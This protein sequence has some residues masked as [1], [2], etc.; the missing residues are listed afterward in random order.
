MS[1][2][3]KMNLQDL[4]ANSPKIEKFFE[5][6]VDIITFDK[7]WSESNS[8]ILLKIL[9]YEV[10][11]SNIVIQWAPFDWIEFSTDKDDCWFT[12]KCKRK[13]KDKDLFS[14]YY[15]EN[16]YK[17]HYTWW[18]E[19]ISQYKKNIRGFLQ[20][21]YNPG[22][23]IDQSMMHIYHATNYFVDKKCTVVNM[24][25]N[26]II[27]HE[28]YRNDEFYLSKIKDHFLYNQIIKNSEIVLN[29]QGDYYW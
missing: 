22:W 11:T 15:N 7:R 9:D 2:K 20:I 16:I 23:F 3:S 17:N 25:P 18:E 10:A 8:R 19:N 5:N 29:N 28:Q 24:L 27:Q 21:G 12:I 1:Y 26:V 6:D 13:R 14:F 4:E